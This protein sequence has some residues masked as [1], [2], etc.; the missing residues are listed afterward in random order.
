VESRL[1]VAVDTGGTFTDFVALDETS[2]T[3]DVFKVP[4]TRGSEADGIVAGLRAYLERIG[5]AGREVV[6]F[7]HG[8]TVGTNAMLEENGARTGLLVTAGFRGI[9]EVGEQSRPYGATTYDLFFERPH[10]LVPARLTEEVPERLLHDGSVLEDLDEEATVEAIRTLV[11][12][13]VTSIAVALLFSFRNPAHERRVGE[14]IAREAP[15][16]NVSLSSD[17]APQ[18]REY[19]RL[20][21]T[22][23]N[24]YLNPKLE[25]YIDELDARLTGEG[26]ERPQRYIMRSNGG[27]ATFGS[28]ARRS[29]QTILSGPAAGVVA[30]S[31]L[32]SSSRDFPN[33]VT[34]DMGGTSTDVALIENGRP[35]RRTGGKVHGRDVQVPMLDIH[36]VAAGGGTIA[37][38]DTAGVLQVGPKSAGANPGPVCYGTGGTEP[39]I[40]D[41][42][43]VLGALSEDNPLAGGTLRLDRAAA[44]KAIRQRIAEPLGISVI[45]A[46]RG[47]VEIVSVKMQEA[48][49]V[50][51]SN[52]GYDL[53]DFHLLA[54]GGAGAIHAAK[55][56]AE[57][58]MRGVLVPAFP[59]VTSALGLLLSDVRH[60]YVVSKLSDIT[61]TDLALIGE[62]FNGL[63][64]QGERELLEQGFSP[65]ALRFEYA[66]DLRYVGQG[67]DLTVVVDEVPAN[68]AAIGD[69]RARFDAQHAQLTGHSAPDE[70]VEIVNY[71]VTA[72]AAVPQ[73]SISSP[74]SATGT[75]AEARLGERQTWIE[76]EQPTTTALY[77]RAKLP[78]GA[79]I[80]G[81]AILLQNDATTVVGTGQRARVVELGQIEI[82]GS[83]GSTA[84][85]NA[86]GSQRAIDAVT[87]QV[88]QSRLSGIVSEMQDSIFRTGYS[89]IIRESQD[90]SCM[91]LDAGGNV[92]G[93]NVVL[94]L[95]ISALPEVVRAVRRDF[96]DI[97]PGDAFITNHPYLAGVTH[98]MDMAVVTPVFHDGK[99]IAF[100]GSIAHKSDLGGVVPGTSYGSARELFQEGIQY[101]P[102]RFIAGGV[103]LRDIEAILRAN[104]R[105]PDL[106]IGDIRG[107]VGVGRLG[108]RRIADLIARYGIGPVR[109]TFS[110]LQD[111]TERRI[112]AVLGTWPDGV[113]EAETYVDTDGITLD[114]PVRYHVRIE[115]RGDRI[116]FDFTGCN[117]QT[118]GPVN[119]SPSLA[120]GCCYYALI[121]MIDPALPNNA[122]VARVVE[123]T[124]RKGS[125]VDPNFPAPCCTYMASTTALA[126]I[127]LNALSRFVPA[128][129]MAG[130]GGVGGISITG[131]RPDGATFVQYEPMG[132]AYGGRATSDGVSGIAVLLSNTRTASIEVLES[133]FPTRVRRFELIRDSGGPGRYRGGLSP[134][135]V[136][137]ILVDDAQLTCRGGK[138]TVP[139][140]GVDGGLPGALGS[141]VINAGI[142]EAKSLPSRF[143]GVRLMRGDRLRME[144]AGGGGLGH[145]NERPLAA[146]VADVL[147]GY[148]SRDAAIRDYG[149]DATKIDEAIAAWAGSPVLAR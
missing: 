41:A 28:A 149:A 11:R 40:T 136:W 65:A 78:P 91:L 18:I 30:A 139:P 73:A 114:Q 84:P 53:R 7:S 24:A 140:D 45:E 81:P 2:G 115:K 29:V 72:V 132:S 35:V 105:T 88:I 79:V 5:A 82:A 121:A 137:E 116:A 96:D 70:R 42:N 129:R 49:K 71:R 128:R 138:H 3:F 98:S 64:A 83:A 85:A 67:Y 99:L 108:E 50:V 1:R 112:R 146:V 97:A 111:V 13:G 125:V 117:D 9:Y 107:Q 93:E 20:S 34:F 110:L 57:L 104:S 56:A 87:F 144:R 6:Y 23:V 133:E 27:V 37:W 123:T 80:D 31:R 86:S 124:F 12:H 126:E 118:Q 109:E 141:L 143:S 130:N 60:D 94:P 32:I 15:G 92:V 142:S 52:R 147:D 113:H 103:P 55:M 76:G 95:H 75:V 25:H 102:I 44:E 48:I 69:V 68:G 63:R 90:A 62:I 131:K 39:T 61:T 26:C 77:D 38:I 135:R 74:F 58:G 54:F 21:S 119:I 100:C 17:V 122:G 51:S 33:V 10:A 14:L 89:T 127:M 22:V 16:V 36:T 46:A 8:T 43:V 106:V 19:Y 47:I 101:P 134:R 145:P 66:F 120:R 59:G 148:V 4:S